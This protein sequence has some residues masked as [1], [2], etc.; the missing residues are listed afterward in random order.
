MK[1]A[2][3]WAADPQVWF[4]QIES[5]FATRRITSQLTMFHHVIGSLS[6]EYAAEV[7][8]LILRP[9][10]TVPFDTLKAAL[11]KRTQMSE[12]KRLQRPLTSEDLGDRTPTQMLR[13]MQQLLGSNH[14]DE[15]LFRSLFE[16][17]LPPQV[18]MVLASSQAL[19]IDEVTSMAD[20]I[21]EV[22]P[23]YSS[24]SEVT[25]NQTFDVL[26]R[27]Q[28]QVAALTTA[29]KNLSSQ[30]H[31]HRRHSQSRG[32]SSERYRSSTGIPKSAGE[33]TVTE[34]TA[35]CFYHSRYGKEARKCESPC[36]FR[37]GNA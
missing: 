11:I 13:H 36:S 37:S 12:Q 24:I 23:P 20:R 31:H 16:Q 27:L 25:R 21:M 8:D 9:P 26:S 30:H 14:L 32:R 7:R 35:H 34:A 2:P 33:N 22:A 28:E 15:S 29:V 3:Y 6:P 5:L 18:R 10:S 4:A 17:R 19:S 1:L